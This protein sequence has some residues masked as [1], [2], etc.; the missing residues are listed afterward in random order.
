VSPPT[1]GT[2]IDSLAAELNA[3]CEQL[4]AQVS[5]TV[6]TGSLPG[7]ASPLAM[8]GAASPAPGTATPAVR[9]EWAFAD[10][11]IGASGVPDPKW[12]SS[13]AAEMT[14]KSPTVTVGLVQSSSVSASLVGTLGQLVQ[15]GAL[16]QVLLVP[17]PG[18]AGGPARFGTWVQLVLAALKPVQLV[19]IGTGGAPAGSNAPTVAAYTEAGLTAAR[20]A[21]AKVATGVLWLDGGTS[22]DDGAVW[23]SLAAAGAWSSSSFMARSL[24]AAAAC[25]SQSGFVTMERQNAVAAALPLVSE[26]VPGAAPAGGRPAEWSCLKGSIAQD[27]GASSAFW[28]EWQGPAS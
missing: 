7:G 28:R 12:P 6:P 13:L 22:S 4:L 20:A 11:P 19:E 9:E 1:T 21:S 3:L 14:G 23:S 10:S 27:T 2:P 25:S 26:A 17:Q 24:D 16:V 18:A 8:G 5:G 15:N